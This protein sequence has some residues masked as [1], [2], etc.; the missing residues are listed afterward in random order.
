MG[1]L[2]ETWE[3]RYQ[4]NFNRE[5]RVAEFTRGQMRAR[6]EEMTG[7]RLR[8]TYQSAPDQ[9]TSE[10]CTPDEAARLVEAVLLRERLVRIS[11]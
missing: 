4:F 7:D 2:L 10:I 6:V 1:L 11:R 9:E 5:R 8:V 3:R